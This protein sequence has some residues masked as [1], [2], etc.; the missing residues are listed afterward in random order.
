M[1]LKKKTLKALVDA[2]LDKYPFWNMIIEESYLVA[3]S[4]N[5]EPSSLGTENKSWIGFDLIS[6]YNHKNYAEND[7][8]FSN[9]LKKVNA[10]IEWKPYISGIIQDYCDDTWFINETIKKPNTLVSKSTTDFQESPVIKAAQKLGAVYIPSD[11]NQYVPYQICDYNINNSYMY[12]LID[13][14]ATLINENLTKNQQYDNLKSCYKKKLQAKC[15]INLLLYLML[16]LNIIFII[17][18]ILV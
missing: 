6:G 13:Q 7:F 18:Y 10:T 8:N 4:K 12:I 17:Y 3:R 1:I 11:L 9:L 15:F 14:N 2:N 16:F 5:N